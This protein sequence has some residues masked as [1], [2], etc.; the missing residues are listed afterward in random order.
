MGNVSV[1]VKKNVVDVVR[2]LVH[3]IYETS[4]S[5]DPRHKLVLIRFWRYSRRFEVDKFWWIT[6]NPIYKI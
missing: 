5:V 4:F 2:E 6:Q 1:C 3:M